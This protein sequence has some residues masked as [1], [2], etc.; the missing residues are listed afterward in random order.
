MALRKYKVI[1]QVGQAIALPDTKSYDIRFCIGG[2]YIT[3]NPRQQKNPGYG[4]SYGRSEDD[5]V[6]ELPYVDVNDIGRLIIQLMDGNKP[7]CYY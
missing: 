5:I 4:K 6:L 3:I 2:E 1:A 7:I